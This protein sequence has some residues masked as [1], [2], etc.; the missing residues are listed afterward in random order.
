[1]PLP[2]SGQIFIADAADS[3]SLAP[4]ERNALLMNNHL[5]PLE[6]TGSLAYRSIN[7]TSLRDGEP[8]NKVVNLH[9]TL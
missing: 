8:R 5:A 2:P 3:A 6:R 1:M 4:E 7:I 9:N